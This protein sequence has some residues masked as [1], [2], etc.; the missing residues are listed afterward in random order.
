MAWIETLI[1]GDGARGEPQEWSR[2]ALAARAAEAAAAAA[3]L[4]PAGGAARRQ[5]AALR[6]AAAAAEEECRRWEAEVAQQRSAA[7]AT[8]T[9]EIPGTASTAAA[10]AAGPAA[11]S[12]PP[13]LGPWTA[14]AEGLGAEAEAGLRAALRE[15]QEAAAAQGRVVQVTHNHRGLRVVQR[16]GGVAASCENRKAT[17]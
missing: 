5:A 11:T 4:A 14:E 2:A 12:A 7:A 6:A 17:W 8:A 16:G 1:Y 3:P 15:R 13:P 9:S 10:A